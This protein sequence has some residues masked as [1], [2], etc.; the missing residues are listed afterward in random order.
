MSPEL[1]LI[2]GSAGRVFR[3]YWGGARFNVIVEQTL[4]GYNFRLTKFPF[5]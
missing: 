4:Q 3:A 5:D 2:Q 1:T